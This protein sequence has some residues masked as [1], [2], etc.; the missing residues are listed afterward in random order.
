MENNVLF[1][2]YSFFI[3]GISGIVIGMFFDIF[4]ILRKSFRTPDIITYIEDIL[5]WLITGFFLIFILFF[6]S[7]GEIRI[8]SIIGLLFGSI[9]YML[10]I[11]KYFININVS[12]ITC[13]KNI[14]YHILKYPIKLCQ[15]LLRKLFK[16]F[17]FFVINIKKS[18]LNFSQKI[19]NKKKKHNKKEKM[20]RERRILEKNV[21]KYI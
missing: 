12:I 13:M 17:T 15:F 5:F 9:L 6:I 7:N 21:E 8:Y 4:R 2:L 19:K 20:T 11:S 1:Q 16:P 10:T 14:L 3:Y 18:S